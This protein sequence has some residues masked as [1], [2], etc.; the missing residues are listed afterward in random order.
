M[1]SAIDVFLLTSLWEGLPRVIPQAL[2]MEVPV[3][4][5]RVDGS[6]EAIIQGE[7]GFLCPAGDIECL[8][9]CCIELLRDPARRQAMGTKGHTYALKEFDLQVM[10]KQ[11]AA[12]YEEL[13]RAKGNETPL[14]P[15][16]SSDL[17]DGR[18]LRQKRRDF[19]QDARFCVSKLRP[20]LGRGEG[21]SPAGSCL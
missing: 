7:T 13:L 2:A 6:A 8:S 18:P 10:V 14:P 4:A 3:V 9:N 20:P 12:L 21:I 5:N 15:S 16:T 1:L 17:P 11:I 19:R